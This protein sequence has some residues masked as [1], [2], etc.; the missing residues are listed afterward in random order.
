MYRKSRCIF[1]IVCPSV[2]LSVIVLISLAALYSS[3]HT[4]MFYHLSRLTFFFYVCIYNSCNILTEYY[5]DFLF[6]HINMRYVIITG[7]YVSCQI[8]ISLSTQCC[9][10]SALGDNNQIINQKFYFKLR[11]QAKFSILIMKRIQLL[12]DDQRVALTPSNEN[13]NLWQSEPLLICK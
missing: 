1:S 8:T 12:L 3:L 5:Y 10:Q 11:I 2:L 6:S 7:T 9:R 4:D 13:A